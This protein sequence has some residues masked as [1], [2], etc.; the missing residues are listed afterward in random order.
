MYLVIVQCTAL[1]NVIVFTFFAG[2]SSRE[3]EE[4]DDQEFH[5]AQDGGSTMA[6]NSGEENSFIIK[7]PVSRMFIFV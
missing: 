3:S 5:D 4:E 6:V 1:I 2:G 7:I